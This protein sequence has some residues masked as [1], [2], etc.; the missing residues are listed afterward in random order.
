MPD[1]NLI[2][3]IAM[4]ALMFVA[5]YLLILRPQR[6]RQAQQRE[7]LERM[8]PGDRV[9]TSTGVYATLLR[10]GEKQ[11]VLELSPGNE[12]TVVKH[13][14]VRVLEPGE[15]DLEMDSGSTMDSEEPGDEPNNDELADQAADPEQ[16]DDFPWA[17]KNDSRGA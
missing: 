5:F 14:I 8:Q 16:G 7:I 4:I 3:T 1:Q 13:A 2:T 17:D 11:A 15:E 9:L 12:M 6:K 10:L